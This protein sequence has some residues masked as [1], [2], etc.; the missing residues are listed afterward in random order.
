MCELD[1][2]APQ[3][4]AYLEWYESTYIKKLE[5]SFMY[6]IY[7]N[8]QNT[9]SPHIVLSAVLPII[10]FGFYLVNQPR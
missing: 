10:W 3:E 2:I 7:L 6:N 5:F 1:H 4:T 8:K 9:G